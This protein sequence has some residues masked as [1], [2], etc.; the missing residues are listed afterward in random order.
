MSAGNLFYSENRIRDLASILILL[1]SSLAFSLLHSGNFFFWDTVTEVSIPA[2]WYYDN[3]FSHLFIP[4]EI[5][6]GHPTFVGIYIAFL[7]KIFG[8]TLFV[9]HIAMFPF[10]FG[11]LFQINRYI[12]RSDH[13]RQFSW[14]VFIIVVL[15]AT[16]ISQMSLVTFDIVQ[17]FLYVW[18]INNIIARK[19]LNL[20]IAFIFL[21]MTSM[22][23]IIC[24]GG[25]LLFN[26]LFDYCY[27]RKITVR[28]ILPYIPGLGFILAFGIFYLAG[29]WIMGKG[30]FGIGQQTFE[31]PSFRSF[32][33]NSAIISWRIIDYGRLGLWIVFGYIIFVAVKRKSLFDNFIRDTLLIAASQLIVFLPAL[34]FLVRFIGHR[35]LLPVYLM[36]AICTVYWVLRYSQ[37]PLL[38]YVLIIA[39][40]VSG[41]SWIY[42]KTISQ[43]WDSTPAHWPYYKLRREMLDIM[44]KDSVPYSQTGSFFPNLASSKMIDLTSDTSS[45]READFRRD[46]YILYSNIYN[47][48]DDKI[49]ELFLSDRWNKV[50]NVERRGVKVILFKRKEHK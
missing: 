14:P 46:R 15:D 23:G 13:A 42:P 43:G 22:R 18:C 48:S 47:I 21:C 11:T 25:I 34:V 28:T 9:S 39:S 17:I 24:A 40:L 35:Y 27:G 12:D 4:D 36:V 3:N 33:L 5:S 41:Y 16:F 32:F 20:G 31:N 19:P 49:N 1:I 30:V 29:H 50:E 2:N 26:L 38:I 44:R 45:F 37:K 8:K 10:I 7:W 6:S